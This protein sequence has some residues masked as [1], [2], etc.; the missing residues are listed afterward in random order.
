MTLGAPLTTVNC[1]A[2]RGWVD[3]TNVVPE[4]TRT[5]SRR[6]TRRSK[7][8]SVTVL[9]APG[10][11]GTV[12]PQARTRKGSEDLEQLFIDLTRRAPAPAVGPSHWWG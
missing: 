9:D 3:M 1:S 12:P 4:Q 6:A 7:D 10:V 5:K 8:G 11:G 2:G